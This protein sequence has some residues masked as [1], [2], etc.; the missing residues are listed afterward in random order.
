LNQIFDIYADK[1]FAC[2]EVFWADG[3]YGHLEEILPK[4]SKVTKKI[5]KR[6]F[7]ELRSRADEA[8]LNL[9]RFMRYKKKE[10]LQSDKA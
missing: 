4:M 7:G 1:S 10:K 8:V 3:F 6:K 9:G 5:D 2:D